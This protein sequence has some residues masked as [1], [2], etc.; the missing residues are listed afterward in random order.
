[1]GRKKIYYTTVGIEMFDTD[2]LFIITPD[3]ETFYKHFPGIYKRLKIEDTLEKDFEIIKEAIN[4]MDEWSAITQL[5]PGSVFDAIVVM[6]GDSPL[7]VG[8]NVLV[9][10][11]FHAM[12]HI[13][14]R[15]GVEDEETGAYILE[16]L[17]AKTEEWLSKEKQKCAKT[18]S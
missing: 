8:Y 15:K 18:V 12:S 7:D 6:V 10:E 2:I 9:H 5:Y 1:M 17:Y 16:Y 4:K 11:C 14:R 3:E 13:C